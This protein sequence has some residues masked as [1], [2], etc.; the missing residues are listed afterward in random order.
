MCA[1]I[2]L[3]AARPVRRL[4]AANYQIQ[5]GVVEMAAALAGVDQLVNS[6]D[7]QPQV[8]RLSLFRPELRFGLR[9]IADVIGR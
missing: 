9:I 8:C 5:P 2:E 3:I 6:L 4:L 7:R 1:M